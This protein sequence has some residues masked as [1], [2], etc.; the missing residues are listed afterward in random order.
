MLAAISSEVDGKL[1]VG[2]SALL[3]TAARKRCTAVFTPRGYRLFQLASVEW[4]TV[5]PVTADDP[6][7]GKRAG[8]TDFFAHY[9]THT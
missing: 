7:M 4:L 6:V 1:E 2:F 8:L 3:L 9:V 5:F